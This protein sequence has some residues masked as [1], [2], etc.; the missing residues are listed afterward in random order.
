MTRVVV[1]INTGEEREVRH[2][3]RLCG[4][5]DSILVENGYAFYY[6]VSPTG[7]AHQIA[8][9]GMTECGINATGHLWWWPL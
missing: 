2:G 1:N 8:D 4:L 7:I 6:V 9:S 5:D 3:C